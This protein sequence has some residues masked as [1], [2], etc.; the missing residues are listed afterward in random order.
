MTLQIVLA[1]GFAFLSAFLV[2]VGIRYRP[3]AW[4]VVERLQGMGGQ[5]EARPAADPL[6]APWWERLLLP[7]VRGVGN[8]IGRMNPLGVRRVQARLEAAGAPA[9]LRAPEYI[10]LRT[11]SWVGFPLLAVLTAWLIPAGLMRVSWYLLLLAIGFFTPDA[12]LNSKVG[13]RQA[14]VRR[15]MPDILDL[16]VVSVQAGLGLDGAMGKVV[17]K[18]NSPLAEEFGR[19]LEEIRL[20]K[21]RGAALKDMANRIGL[22][23]LSAFVAALYQAETLGVSVAHVLT[24]QADTVRERRS[25]LARE[26]AAKL[27]VKMLFPL[28]FF[29][30]PALFVVLLGPSAIAIYNVVFKALGSGR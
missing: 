27:P 16:L 19:V 4:A 8:A 13:K 21:P 24:V 1:C 9:W 15:T 26:H 6:A 18:V 30:F 3:E 5:A 11:L 25:F 12:M 28:V 10:G 17:E 20:G 2:V 14:A 29:I 23:E 22:P 7:A